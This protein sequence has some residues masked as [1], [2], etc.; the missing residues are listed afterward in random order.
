MPLQ[1]RLP[2]PQPR[3][4]M[5]TRPLEVVVKHAGHAATEH[6][7][8]HLS[9]G[10][11]RSKFAP[12]TFRL[13]RAPGEGLG[14]F[15]R[16]YAVESAVDL[17]GGQLLLGHDEHKRQL[18][19]GQRVEQFADAGGQRRPRTQEEGHIGTKAEG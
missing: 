7:A 3:Q 18:G 19:K 9:R 1:R 13:S 17:G 12:R 14:R 4:Q 2:G 16:G 8:R 15:T 5:H 6:R 10:P 11:G